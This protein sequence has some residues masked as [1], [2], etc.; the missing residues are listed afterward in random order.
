VF[1]GL[2][3]IVVEKVSAT[4]RKCTMVRVLERKGREWENSY[5]LPSYA[6]CSLDEE[7]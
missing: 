5:A 7:A 1:P 2:A 6:S 4:A 3:D